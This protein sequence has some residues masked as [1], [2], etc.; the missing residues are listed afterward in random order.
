MIFFL[1]G[2]ACMG[3]IWMASEIRGPMKEAE[4]TGTYAI[5][6][7]LLV[8]AIYLSCYITWKSPF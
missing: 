6:V 8:V 3:L 7:L 1:L 2:F 5:A 4:Q